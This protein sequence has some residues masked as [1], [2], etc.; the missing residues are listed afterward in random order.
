MRESKTNNKDMCSNCKKRKVLDKECSFRFANFLFRVPARYKKHHLGWCAECAELQLKRE[1]NTHVQQIIFPKQSL[2]IDWKK[3][4]SIIKEELGI[5]RREIREVSEAIHDVFLAIGLLSTK[6]TENWEVVSWDGSSL[7]P[8]VLD[9]Y[10]FGS[11]RLYF[12][13]EKDAVAFAAWRW[14]NTNFDWYVNQYG[15]VIPKTEIL[16]K[17]MR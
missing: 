10:Y 5:D 4:V 2:I 16:L 8:K 9:T 13:R 7:N 17:K 12:T 15:K 6:R 14:W 3:Y 1:F 11:P